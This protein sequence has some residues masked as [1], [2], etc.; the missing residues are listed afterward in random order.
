MIVL[1]VLI[2][3]MARS[4]PPARRTS[5]RVL[6]VLA[7]VALVSFGTAIGAIVIVYSEAVF[8]IAIA[9]AGVAAATFIWLAKALPEEDDDD[10]G[11]EPPDAPPEPDEPLRR[12]RRKRLGE[13]RPRVPKG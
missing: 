8:A 13:R 10:G 3:V 7:G 11:E 6:S 5:P 4:R 1:L 9:I 12:F 2:L